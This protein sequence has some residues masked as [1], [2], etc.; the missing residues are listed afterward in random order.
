M[1]ENWQAELNTNINSKQY[2]SKNKTLTKLSTLI[3]LLLAVLALPALISG[4]QDAR[5]RAAEKNN[6]TLKL[7]LNI[8]I[9]STDTNQ[10]CGYNTNCTAAQEGKTCEHIN[11][12]QNGNS[13][14]NTYICKNGTWVYTATLNQ[15]Y[16]NLCRQ[17]KVL[18]TEKRENNTSISPTPTIFQGPTI[19]PFLHR[20][21]R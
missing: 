17:N 11:A 10:S 5:S 15:G 8:P 2:A 19:D 9:C 16:C 7:N 12:C 20:P 21:K 6:N 18:P 14:N 4:T 3:V 13:T 1:E